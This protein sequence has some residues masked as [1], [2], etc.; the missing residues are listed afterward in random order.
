MPRSSRTSSDPGRK[1]AALAAGLNMDAADEMAER[2]P[3]AIVADDEQFIRQILVK[4]LERLGIQVVGAACNGQEAVDLYRSQR[5]DLAVLDIAMPV[6]DGLQAVREIVEL[7]PHARVLICTSF[8][9]KQ[10][11]VDAVRLGAKGYLSKPFDF[12]R[13][14]EKVLRLLS[15]D[16]EGSPTPYA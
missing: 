9:S 14:R 15:P 16:S 13:I 7:D 6:K 10:Y 11:I 2:K 8:S 12:N 5:P 1:P 3:R 4:M